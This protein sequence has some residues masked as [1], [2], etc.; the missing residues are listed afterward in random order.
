M[1]AHIFLVDAEHGQQHVKQVTCSQV[2]MSNRS[3]AH[4]LVH[5]YN[6]FLLVQLF[7]SL[8]QLFNILVQLFNSLVQ[9]FNILVQLFNRIV[10]PV[11]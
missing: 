11:I 7:N 8:V 6:E 4:R 2:S 9:L 3:P 5:Q 10:F 1:I